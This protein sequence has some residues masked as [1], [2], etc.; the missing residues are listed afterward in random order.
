MEEPLVQAELVEDTKRGRK[1]QR[2]NVA[3][4]KLGDKIIEPFCYL[5]KYD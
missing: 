5:R 4:A 3:A 1:F 2:T